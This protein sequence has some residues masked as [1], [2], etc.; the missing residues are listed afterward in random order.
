MNLWQ[1]KLNY[2]QAKVDSDMAIIKNYFPRCVDVQKSSLEE[3]KNGVD[4]IATL[5]GGAKIFIDAKT[6]ERGASRYWKHGEP[7]LALEWY[8]VVE[9]KKIG[10]TLSGSAPVHYILYTFN[11]ADTDKFYMLPFQML[12]KVFL[13]KS[14]EWRA[15]YGEKTQVSD[16]WHSSAI[17]VPASVVLSAIQEVCTKGR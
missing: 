8:S 1:D 2:S 17:F 13:E 5:T 3:D 4:Y 12:R 9:T 15:L 11:P 7:E 10:W 16:S 6:R 14:I